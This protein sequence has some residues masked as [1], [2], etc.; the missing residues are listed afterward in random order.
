MFTKDSVGAKVI[1]KSGV[2]GTIIAFDEND[3]EGMPLRVQFPMFTL[4]YS[5]TGIDEDDDEYSINYY[6][7][8]QT[9]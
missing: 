1:T 2:I 3:T 9:R 8:T 7:K 4:W 6:T 5:L